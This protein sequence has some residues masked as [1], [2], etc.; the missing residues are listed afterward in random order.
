MDRRE[1][2]ATSQLEVEVAKARLRLAAA[3]V[4]PM[5]ELRTGV[6]RAPLIAIASAGVLGLMMGAIPSARRVLP[7]LAATLYRRLG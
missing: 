4:Q 5:A 7:K 3:K 6:R 2:D 1:R